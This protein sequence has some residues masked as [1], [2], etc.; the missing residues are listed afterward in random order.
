[1]LDYG[2]KYNRLDVGPEGLE[3]AKVT[4][5]DFMNLDQAA[6]LQTYEKTK[7]QSS[8]EQWVFERSKKIASPFFHRITFRK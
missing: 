7:G 3:A 6:L 5:A 1:M 2:S 4:N 8:N